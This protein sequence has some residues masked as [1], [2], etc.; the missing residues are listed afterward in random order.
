MNWIM[1]EIHWGQVAVY[2]L[3]NNTFFL[4]GWVWGWRSGRRFGKSE[5]IR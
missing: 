3:V 5:V 1:S 2:V 4:G